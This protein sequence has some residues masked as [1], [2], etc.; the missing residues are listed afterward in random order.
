MPGNKDVREISPFLL[1]R[2]EA[3]EFLG[4]SLNTLEALNIQKT[5][6]RR[7]VMYRRDLLEKWAVDNTE[8]EAVENIGEGA[9]L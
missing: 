9:N 7:R 2:R 6:I 8:K 3:A 4:I 1:N 5:R